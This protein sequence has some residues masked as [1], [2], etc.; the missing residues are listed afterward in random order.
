MTMQIRK[1]T[2]AQKKLRMLVSGQTAS[3]KTYGSL[4]I[5]RGLVENAKVLVFDTESGR[6]SLKSDKFQ[7]DVIEWDE[8]EQGRSVCW[9]DYIDAIYI[10]EKNGYDV[11]ILDSITAEWE[12][13]KDRHSKMSGNSFQNWGKVK[14][15]HNKFINAILHSKIHIICTARSKMEYVLEE[16]TNKDGKKVQ[17]PKRVGLGAEQQNDLPY[18]MDFIFNIIDREHNTEA[19]K[20][21]TEIY[22]NKGYFVINESVGKRI[23][24]WLADGTEISP[25]APP[26]LPKDDTDIYIALSE[27][28]TTEDLE[29]FYKDNK[30]NVNSLNNFIEL[31]K[32][33]K[34][35]IIE[36][37]LGLA[38]D[39][40]TQEVKEE[41]PET[42][43][44]VTEIKTKTTKKKAS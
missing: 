35:A 7:F 25:P 11:L 29:Q 21:E 43:D 40:D 41:T 39:E 17:A 28:E 22:L 13:I 20:D 32:S 34:L 12:E 27:I 36:K 23:A 5:A 16:I 18:F 30:D 42:P 33:R 10:A 26:A 3:G 6:A 8:H 14:P 15:D 1:A 31:C 2:K 44:N 9:S 19:E 4:L 38:P 37:D 24:D